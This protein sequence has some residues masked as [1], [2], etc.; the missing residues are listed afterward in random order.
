MTIAWRTITAF[1]L[2]AA[3]IFGA[4]AEPAQSRAVPL[5]A[6]PAK[7]KPED[8]PDIVFY[9]AKG[10]ANACGR[11]CDEWI[12]ADGKI[13][14]GAPQRLRRLL[15]KLANRRLPI[16]FQSPGGTVNGSLEL[17]RLIRGQ[18]LAAGVARTIPHGCDRDN[19]YAKT[20][21]ALKHSGMQLKSE[22]DTETTMCNS[23]CVYALIGGT[24]RLVP[25]WGGLG[26]HSVGSIPKAHTVSPAVLRAI[27]R[28][29]NSRIDDSLRDMG[30]DVTLR[31]EASA[32][33]FGSMRLLHRDE[34]AGFGIDT[35][36]FAETDWHHVEKPK[37]TAVK[38]FFVR[39]EK[40]QLVHRSAMLGLSCDSAK[41]MTI[42][43]AREVGPSEPAFATPPLIAKGRGWNFDFV[44]VAPIVGASGTRID[45]GTASLPGTL[46][47]LLTSAGD[48]DTFEIVPKFMDQSMRWP[49]S[50]T[51]TMNGFSAAYAA[52]RKSCDEQPTPVTT[53]PG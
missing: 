20:C 45:I 44:M 27:T 2:G 8:V 46:V 39:T 28:L 19:L 15:T 33:P 32:T 11:G 17:G 4:A 50:V 34:F 31:T 41:T 24:T 14:I 25:P 18:K 3:L 1:G 16:F 47:D 51:L 49:H 43:L 40:E 53:S 36:D 52:L 5:K 10:D 22:F 30:V 23:G 35:R 42:W 12:A 6:E 48:A 21:E 26:V 9:V 38:T 13:D 29:A 7:L 37:L